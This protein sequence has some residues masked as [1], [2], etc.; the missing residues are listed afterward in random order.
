MPRAASPTPD[1]PLLLCEGCGYILCGLPNDSRCPECAKPITESLPELRTLP[2]WEHP[3]S[4]HS[5]L[6][7]FGRTTLNVI[8][9][10]SSFYRN[11]AALP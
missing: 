4:Q 10:P 3:D 1:E 8:F 2:E 5:A 11:L 9:Y 6:R 7:R